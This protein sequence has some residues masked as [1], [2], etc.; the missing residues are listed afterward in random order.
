VQRRGIS[1]HLQRA[2]SGSTPHD[3]VAAFQIYSSRSLPLGRP[4]QHTPR[5]PPVTANHRTSYGVRRHLPLIRQPFHCRAT[6]W[7]GSIL[8]S[9]LARGAQIPIAPAARPYVPLSAVSSLGGFRTPAA[10]LAALSL[11]RPAS[12][13]LHKSCPD[14]PEVRLLLCTRK[15]TQDG[16]R[17]MSVR[18]E[19]RHSGSPPHV[20]FTKT[21]RY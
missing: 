1:R 16:H 13:A 19:R 14:C 7:I 21:V 4:R 15:R 8:V 6:C 18:G 20:S 5:Y 3:R 9:Q 2:A 12:E 17:A 11:K 10:E